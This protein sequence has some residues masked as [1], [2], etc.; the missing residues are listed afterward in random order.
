MNTA[1]PTLVFSGDIGTDTNRWKTIGT[2]EWN[3]SYLYHLYDRA[4]TLLYVGMTATPWVRWTQHRR[5]KDWWPEVHSVDVY[6]V[7]GRDRTY[8]DNEARRLES[9]CIR[10]MHPIKNLAGPS[11]LPSK[12]KVTA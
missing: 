9:L 12:R 1:P 10:K 3:R 8:A 2:P 6:E 4:G 7:I 5:K 11:T